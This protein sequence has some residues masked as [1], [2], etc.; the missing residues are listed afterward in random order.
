MGTSTVTPEE[1]CAKRSN[2]FFFEKLGSRSENC[3]ESERL[4]VPETKA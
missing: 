3:Y 1:L 2:Y 4:E